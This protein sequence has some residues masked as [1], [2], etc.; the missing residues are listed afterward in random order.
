MKEKK[1]DENKLF[2]ALKLIEQLNHDGYLPD[3]IFEN[4]LKEYSDVVDITQFKIQNNK[5]RGS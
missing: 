4:I 1:L 2:A 5:N 3:F